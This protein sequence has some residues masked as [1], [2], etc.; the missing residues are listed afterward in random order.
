MD[1][2][3]LSDFK[4]WWGAS[5]LVLLQLPLLHVTC[6]QHVVTVIFSLRSLSCSR[7][8][9]LMSGH[10][11]LPG[12]AF[13]ERNVF[14]CVDTCWK[15]E[16]TPT[17]DSRGKIWKNRK[18]PVERNPSPCTAGMLNKTAD[19]LF[20]EIKCGKLALGELRLKAEGSLGPGCVQIMCISRNMNKVSLQLVFA[21]KQWKKNYKNKCCLEALMWFVQ[22]SESISYIINHFINQKQL[23]VPLWMKF[24][25]HILV[26]INIQ[27]QHLSL[28]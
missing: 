22:P 15:G 1:I 26:N 12:T 23:T 4:L 24:Q 9:N 2:G 13:T 3:K 8:V 21:R 6:F 11:K 20:L 16:A 5:R 10:V 18:Q 19:G 28:M 17:A 14:V 27:N 7:T 25:Y